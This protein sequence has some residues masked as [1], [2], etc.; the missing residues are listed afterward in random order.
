MAQADGAG[1]WRLFMTSKLKTAILSFAILGVTVGVAAA[2]GYG[3][4]NRDGQ[5]GYWRY[6]RDDYYG[7][8]G[9]DRGDFRRGMQVA[10]TIGFED[11]EQQA[12]EDMWKAK[13]FNP[14]P[15]GH[16]HADRGYSRDF[17]NVQ[18]YRQNY[19]NAYA[20]GYSSV[21]RRDRFYR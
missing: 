4:Y 13:P 1:R 10:H 14:Y 9:Y 21:F 19:A 20:E 5:Y 2:Q 6:D 16:N 7:Y 11:G 12:R 15:R 8:S 18:T 3:Y 17:G